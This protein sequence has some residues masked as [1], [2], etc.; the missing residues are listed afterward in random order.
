MN[1]STIVIFVFVTLF[2]LFSGYAFAQK[3]SGDKLRKQIS[4]EN[5]QA[6][7]ADQLIKLAFFFPENDSE[8]A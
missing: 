1:K 7:K 6:S 2:I 3:E 5:D 4:R 8:A